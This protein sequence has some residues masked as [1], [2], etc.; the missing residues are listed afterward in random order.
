MASTHRLCRGR[1]V[2]KEPVTRQARHL[3]QGSRLFE[4]MGGA[5]HHR[6]LALAAQLHLRLTV[7]REHDLVVATHDEQ[8]RRS[9]LAELRTCKIRPSSPGDD[10]GDR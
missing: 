9:H 4:E 7:E 5:R 1:Q 10:S 6:Q 3:L 8:R 2:G